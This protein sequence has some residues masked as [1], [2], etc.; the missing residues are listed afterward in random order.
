MAYSGLNKVLFSVQTSTRQVLQPKQRWAHFQGNQLQEKILIYTDKDDTL[1]PFKKNSNPST[2]G[3]YK[4]VDT[5]HLKENINALNHYQSKA[6]I[7]ISTGRGIQA[8]QANTDYLDGLA[9][10]HYLVFN[11]GEQIYRRNEANKSLKPSEW[12]HELSKQP[13][14]GL[15][16]DWKELLEQ[17]RGW[18]AKA[19]QESLTKGLKA[20]GFEKIHDPEQQLYGANP[21]A[22]Q[23]R[24]SWVI[25]EGTGKTRTLEMQT[26]LYPDQSWQF[27]INP[28]GPWSVEH[29]KRF[30]IVLAN[31]NESLHEDLPKFKADYQ[32]ANFPTGEVSFVPVTNKA[33]AMAYLASTP[34]KGVKY[35]HII[36]AGDSNNDHQLLPWSV[37]NQEKFLLPRTNQTG[38]STIKIEAKSGKHSIPNYPILVGNSPLLPVVN[39]PRKLQINVGEKKEPEQSSTPSSFP[40]SFRKKILHTLA[41]GIHF[42]FSQ[43]KSTE[44]HNLE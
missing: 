17:E 44:D 4:E 23:Y 11:N 7:A 20:A 12:I 40:G 42:Q 13:D 37:L 6:D 18:N 25:K 9:S 10:L 41:E 33:E 39:N 38:S 16:T 35:R 36:S 8:S 29:E 14:I 15:D 28:K 31:L 21:A 43:I 34:R 32:I 24:L 2:S 22:I 30:K 26:E 3:L 19:Y 1:I 5:S 27:W